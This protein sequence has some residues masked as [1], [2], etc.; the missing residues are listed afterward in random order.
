M[1]STAD[2]P[3][4]TWRLLFDAYPRAGA[5]NM[6]IDEAVARAVAAREAP[7]T[8]RLY[9]WSPP[10][11]TLGRGQLYADAD[12]D[13]LRRAGV[14]LVRRMTG[15]TAVLNRDELSYTVAVTDREPRLAWTSIA[16]SYRGISAALLYALARLGLFTAEA[17]TPAEDGQRPR[18]EAR[19]PVCFELPSDYE[20][21]AGGRK[22]FGSS[23]M[24]IRGGILQHGSLPLSGDIADIS[25]FLVARPD[26]ARI[27][28]LAL[29]LHDALG[30][31][32]TWLEAAEAVVDG[33]REGLV[34]DLVPGPLTAGERAEVDRLVAEK[35]GHRAWTERV[36]DTR[37]G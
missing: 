13:A 33:F 31:H 8:L 26:P 36:K 34:L 16:E 2:Y 25:A 1:S 28:S 24:R 15:G 30:R 23:Q 37:Q 5:L 19:S 12:L 29:T 11:L 10:T 7:P 4:A 22:L 6:A 14:D 32:V 18:R 27:R 20:I 17:S 35:Y 21:T 9:G 3:P